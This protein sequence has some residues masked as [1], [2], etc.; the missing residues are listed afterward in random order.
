MATF[1]RQGHLPERVLH[2]APCTRC[3]W[4]ATDRAAY[5]PRFSR[6][7]HETGQATGPRW[8]RQAFLAPRG[9]FRTAR[10]L[11][12]SVRSFRRRPGSVRGESRGGGS[13]PGSM[14]DRILAAAVSVMRERGVA[15][16]TTKEIARVAGV[17]EGSIYNHFADKAELV[18]ASMTEMAERHP[19]RL[20][21]PV[22]AGRP[23][24]GGGQPRGVRRGPDPLLHRP[25]ADHRAGAG[26]PRPA[27]VVARRMARRRRTASPPRLR[28]SAT[29][30]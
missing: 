15:H 10:A 5:S 25:V 7:R 20:H 30:R 13:M 9:P 21:T 12:L 8:P 22:A 14:R 24:L 19:R 1:H 6:Q 27:R 17:A 26:R 23:E 4:H 11:P 2:T 3:E 18:A 29:P 16:T 28:F